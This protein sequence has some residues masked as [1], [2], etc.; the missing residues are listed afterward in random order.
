MPDFPETIKDAAFERSKGRCECRR[1]SHKWH[2]G[3]RCKTII[4]RNRNVHYH[5]IR[6]KGPDT[7]GNCEALCIRCHRRTRSYGRSES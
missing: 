7:L 6:S 5:H 2:K 3:P 1:K 4:G